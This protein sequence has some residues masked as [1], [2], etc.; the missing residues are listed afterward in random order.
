MAKVKDK[1]LK[2]LK[3]KHFWPSIVFFLMFLVLSISMIAG[4]IEL[5]AAYVVETKLS[6]QYRQAMDIGNI[7]K[8]Y[9]EDG[10]YV[11]YAVNYLGHYRMNHSDVYVTDLEGERISSTGGGKPVLDEKIE[12]AAE[13]ECILYKDSSW[14]YGEEPFNNVDDI[15]R[16]HV[17]ELAQRALQP[18][19]QGMQTR[20]DF[21][22][23]MQEPIIKQQF[24]MY[25]PVNLKKYHL[26]VR[27]TIQIDRQNVIYLL[28]MG[29]IAFVLLL[30]PLLFL[31]INTI[32]SIRTQKHVTKVLYM[33][34]VTGGNNW[35]YFQGAASKIMRNRWNSRKAYVMVNLHMEHYASYVSFFG[36]KEGEDLL[37][38]MDGFL[39]AR[40]KR[41]EAFGHHSSADFGLIFPCEGS[42]EAAYKEYSYLR[43]RSLL[44]ELAG[45]KPERK[46]SFQ[47]GVVMIPPAM[48]DTGKWNVKR[49]DLDI[50]Q[51]FSFASTARENGRKEAAQI[52][53]FNQQ[54]L[55]AQTWD[56][57]VENH[58]NSALAAGE[59]Q[60]YL[61]PKYRP[62]DRRLVGAEALVR[63]FCPEKGMISP[64]MFIPIFEANGFIAKLDDYMLAQVAKI[65]S[66]WKVQGKKT[67]PISVN[68]SRVHFANA[69]LA[70]HIS[71]LVDSY[72]AD[73]RLVELEVTE[74]AFF[75]DKD[76]LINTI[77]Q[78]R[79]Y[80]FPI[81]MD[82]FGAGYSS[83][84][85]LKDIPL[86]TLKLDAEFFRGED[87]LGRGALI[88]RETISLARE[89][90]MCVVAEGIE[91]RE[92]VDFLASLGC[93]MIQG[94]YFAKPMPLN[95]FE[96]KM[97]ADA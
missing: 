11:Y 47:A 2:K 34:A 90:H 79:A 21:D 78:L 84:N 56:L 22:V 36:R 51:M 37:E 50:D 40:M 3:K 29:L 13:E 88:V 73:H 15:F 23:W 85:S 54:M 82:D 93:D 81:S 17:V 18:P 25:V 42:N 6:A 70:E 52:S 14:D 69:G 63:W 49:K 38:C 41:K 91:R 72:G 96:E 43:L 67:V 66:E 10:D 32:L 48:S 5:F 62:S 94:Y 77:K 80:G 58:M 53:F 27:G 71:R 7:M 55:E 9:V 44:A 87:E 60:V 39:R 92:Q 45:L 24:W 16:Y 33:D 57:W 4:G 83:L 97:A 1:A 8:S 28:G 26:Y 30:I 64:G 12:W 86:D 95:E 35:L 59:F 76:M 61:Q 20:M 31:L 74:S 46:L 65:Q 68:V 75:D 19:P 89:L